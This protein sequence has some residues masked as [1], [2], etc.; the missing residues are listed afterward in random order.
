VLVKRVTGQSRAFLVLLSILATACAGERSPRYHQKLIILGVDGLDPDLVSQF[1]DAGRLP[2]MQKLAKRGSL[3]RLET[4]PSPGTP[5]WASFATGTNPGK[6]GV[7]GEEFRPQRRGAAFWSL[8]GQAGVRSSILAVPVTFPPEDVPAGELLAG[9]PAPD[10]R[11]TPGIYTYFSTDVAQKDDG[12]TMDGG[13]RHRLTFVDNVAHST[14]PGPLGD[15]LP[16]S[17]FWNKEDKAATIEIDGTSIRLEQT[18]WSKWIPIDF[19]RR[20]FERTRGMIELCLVSAGPSFAL[21]ASPIHW[22]ADHPPAPLSAPASL[23]SDLYERIG[24]FRTLGWPEA[25]AAFDA[26]LLDEKTF[27]DDVNRAF[28]DRAQIILQR[29]DTKT[30]DLLVGEIDA[31]DHVEHVMWRLM[32]PAH[33]AHD[34]TAAAKFGDAVERMYRRVDDLLGEIMKHADADTTVLVLSAYGEHAVTQTFDLN[35]WLA[36]EKLP[37]TA[38][39]TTAGGVTLNADARA[40]QD[41]LIARL[42]SVLDPTTHAPVISAVYRRD[43]VYS[44][45]FAASAPD[46]QVGFVPG[47]SVS[48]A[49]SLFAANKRRWSADHA[50]VD[51]KSVPGTLI[52]SRPTTSDSPRVIDIAPTVLRYFGVP[53]PSEIDGTPLF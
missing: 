13:V 30:W 15:R 47:Y 48:A 39:A 33:P 17:F 41:H 5:A 6:H 38:S 16:V 12:V 21:Y 3:Q 37:G 40:S 46:V 52:S 50:A 9:W 32:D 18:E 1:M 27:M 2:N 29:L 45:P 49:P 20:W 53:I 36:D 34:R 28:D 22:K 14:I 4:T 24:P 25:T 31:V 44:G 23:S 7:F 26:G 10:L 19:H 43:A 11:D 42:T 8:A 35:R 51:Y